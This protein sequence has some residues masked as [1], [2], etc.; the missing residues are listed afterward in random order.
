MKVSDPI[1]IFQKERSASI[2][3]YSADVDFVKTSNEWLKLAFDRRYMYNFSWF[4]RPIIQLPADMVALQE[5]IFESE[6]DL[7]VETGIAHGGSLILSASILALLEMQ[8]AIQNSLEFDPLSPKSRVLG[9]DIDIRAHNRSAIEAHPLSNWI[10]M[11][12]GSSVDQSVIEKVYEYAA[13]FERILIVL[14]S[15]HTHEHV[16]RELEAYAPLVGKGCHC[17]V[18]DTAIE[19][20]PKEYFADRPW[21]H[22]DNSATAIESYLRILEEEGRKALD[23]T[24]LRLELDKEIN[25]KLLV[26]AA[27]GGY[28]RRI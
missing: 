15:N 9:I 14:D 17:I 6:P 11:I 25:D 5:A 3:S 28:L 21:G 2:A 19:Y 22:G 13:D 26:G 16:L 1:A 8:N 20:L 10:E 7:I 23:G 4:G 12:E 18:F 24:L 27:P